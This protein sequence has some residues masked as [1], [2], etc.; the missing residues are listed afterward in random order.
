MPFQR[1]RPQRMLNLSHDR[2]GLQPTA[3][4]VAHHH[5]NPRVWK[6]E[7]IVPVAADFDPRPSRQIPRRNAHRRQLR[8]LLPEQAALQRL[9]N[10][11]L[12]SIHAG[13]GDGECGP[14]GQPF[15]HH[16]VGLFVA[17]ARFCRGKGNGPHRLPAHDN[18][19]NHRRFEAQL[20]HELILLFTPRR[21]A[22]HH[23]GDLRHE[24]G[25]PCGNGLQHWVRMPRIG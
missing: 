12:V 24:L 16:Q 2:C 14:V 9:G 20:L 6:E 23:L 7:D 25:L 15:S 19:N 3:G 4:H 21:A 10:A 5:S 11:P 18:R 22:Q 8:Q 1:I 17:T 13:V